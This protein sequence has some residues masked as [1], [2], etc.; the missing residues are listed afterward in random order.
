MRKFKI[1][2]MII[3]ISGILL[4]VLNFVTGYFGERVGVYITNK[5]SVYSVAVIE[6]AIRDE[7]V[8]RID[9][10]ELVI[11][12]KDEKNVI[13]N[14]NINTAIVNDILAH[15]NESVIS[16]MQAIEEERLTLP[17]GIIVSDTLFGSLGPEFNIRLVP[18]GRAVTD[19][20]AEVSPYGINSSLL[21]V[22][23]KVKVN[24]ETIIPLRKEVVEIDFNIPLVMQV[25][26]SDVP[27]F[28]VKGNY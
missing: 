27:L 26:N 2:L 11:F 20:V 22:S 10:H 7:V 17:L 16:S 28:Y 15:V 25:I 9:V 4:F 18:M 24:I 8:D 19:V 14:V 13:T 6:E 3:I 1:Y 5:A 21:E 12:Q 23:I